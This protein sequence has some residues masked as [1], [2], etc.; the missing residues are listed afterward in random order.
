MNLNYNKKVLIGVALVLYILYKVM[1]GWLKELPRVFHALKVAG[2][3]EP[4]TYGLRYLLTIIFIRLSVT[5]I[6]CCA[7]KFH[8]VKVKKSSYIKIWSSNDRPN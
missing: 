8:E 6:A 7:N 3:T 1:G 2:E 4:L 5:L